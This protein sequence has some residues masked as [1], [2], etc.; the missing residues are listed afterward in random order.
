ME[1]NEQLHDKMYNAEPCESEGVW[2]ME[3]SRSR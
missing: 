2:G 1:N 3:C